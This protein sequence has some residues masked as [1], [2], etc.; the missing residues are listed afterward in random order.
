MPLV[1]R[2]AVLHAEQR[3]EPQWYPQVENSVGKRAP[4]RIDPGVAKGVDEVGID[5]VTPLE[6]IGPEIHVDGPA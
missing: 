3:R 1:T 6:R 2:M 5:Q 4:Y